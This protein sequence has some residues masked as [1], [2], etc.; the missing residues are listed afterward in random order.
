MQRWVYFVFPQNLIIL[1]IALISAITRPDF[2]VIL[3]LIAVFVIRSGVRD[4]FKHLV[5]FYGFS[6]VADILWL[7][8]EGNSAN[9]GFYSK[10]IAKVDVICGSINCFVKVTFCMSCLKVY[11]EWNEEIKYYFRS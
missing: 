5:F 10:D 7:V 9:N 8:I 6:L 1:L 2:N 3:S 11:N 4:S